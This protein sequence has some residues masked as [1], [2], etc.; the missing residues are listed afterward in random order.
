MKTRG[1]RLTS[2]LVAVAMTAVYLTPVLAQT[3]LCKNVLNYNEWNVISLPNPRSGPPKIT[4]HAVDPTNADVIYAT[5]GTVVAVSVDAGCSWKQPY[6]AAPA[7]A[8]PSSVK[9]IDA[10]S[11]N[12]AVL[13]IQRANDLAGIPSIAYT[14]DAG[15]TWSEGGVG[16]PPVGTIEFL[17]SPGDVRGVMYAGIDEGAGA[18]D[19]LYVSNDNGATWTLRSDLSKAT[20]QMSIYGLSADPQ[21]PEVL[22]AYGPGGLWK[23][24]DSGR[25][26]SRIP[27]LAGENVLD[28][29][30]IHE[31]G[32]DARVMAILG[33]KTEALLSTNGGRNFN[34]VPTPGQAD[35]IDHGSADWQFVIT[36]GGNTYLYDR[37]NRA[38]RNLAP[39]V[40]GTKDVG[41]IRGV[42]ALGLSVRTNNVIEVYLAG[43]TGYPPPPL[44]AGPDTS[45]VQPPSLITKNA[46]FGPPGKQIRLKT[47]EE[48]TIPYALSLP[49]RRLPVDV[50]FLVDTSSSMKNTI[51]S[52]AER[53]GD[54]SNALL[55][56]KIDVQF[57]LAVYRSYPNSFPPRRECEPGG[58]STPG[59]P[60]E[61]NYVYEK[62]MEI[63]NDTA[64]LEEGLNGLVADAGGTY[65]AHLEALKAT[66]MGEE[67]D[68]APRG[69]RNNYDVQAGEQAHFRDKGLKV[70]IHATDEAYG[71]VDAEDD[72]DLVDPAR[73]GPPPDIPPE[74]PIID[75]FN[76]N[77]VKHVGLS[78]GRL[79]Y[80]DMVNFSRETETLATNDVDCDQNGVVDIPAGAPLV[81]KLFQE[82][83]ES[84][85]P[86]IAPAVVG[87][88]RAIQERSTVSLLAKE[89]GS[90]VQ[91]G[92]SVIKRVTPDS[93][94][95]VVL[96]TANELP[97][98][99]TYTCS[100]SQ[101]GER[102][103]MT[104]S[105]FSEDLP[106]L[107][108]HKVEAEVICLDKKK[109]KE[110][111][112]TAAF[113][114]IPLIGLV[115]PPPPPPP[116]A[117][118]SQINPASQTQAQAQG[119]AQAAAAT[120]EEE[121]PQLAYVTAYN[122]A[123]ENEFAM[124][125]YQ[126]RRRGL[127]PGAALG[128]GALSVTLM[129]GAGL[130]Y[131]RRTR[132][133]RVPF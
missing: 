7:D 110:E 62:V 67:V 11:T 53:L 87:L 3:P 21:D 23:S 90:V 51:T 18:A 9:M 2:F 114:P 98:S 41:G 118:V 56:L 97:F 85:I 75:E 132:V 108:S 43:G 30:V 58:P 54:I 28:A 32:K 57:G 109:E 38:W 34:V 129:Y 47:G 66:I 123:M 20:P 61:N 92:E 31:Q 89:Q 29:D 24:E 49:P 96:Q 68:L 17:E 73:N 27:D 15:Q 116:P 103:D 25:S 16:L 1:R 60:C 70:V 69:V 45:I 40:G 81:C 5:N 113:L 76:A 55:E 115:L 101:A 39:P 95:D 122:D 37:L 19:L 22:F 77:N 91:E 48:K 100:K 131:S 36:G 120:Q 94:S 133:E 33:G 105:P 88:L 117:P 119:Q 106:N 130:A 126:S 78:I 107:D 46:T 111:P 93:Y 63:S 13:G 52:L 64:A 42:P 112:F 26:F 104:F 79:P 128:I 14:Q 102:F 44:V 121:Q 35:S 86:H 71:R 124:S 6:P 8:L 10:P 83:L 82:D 74:Q 127:P 84:E 65:D 12:V 99:V 80:K 50:F 125:A 59:A 72:D 4:D